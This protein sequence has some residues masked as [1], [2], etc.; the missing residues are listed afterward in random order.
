MRLDEVTVSERSTDPLRGE[1]GASFSVYQ[2]L[3]AVSAGEDLQM[4]R[5]YTIDSA[6]NLVPQQ[7]WRSR[8]PSPA[9]KFSIVYYGTEFL[10]SGLGFSPLVEAI[11]N[12]SRVG[13]L[14]IF[15]FTA[16]LFVSVDRW[17]RRSGRVG[18]LI[19]C[20]LLPSIVNWNRIDFAAT[21]K[22]FLV[23]S[24][25]LW[26]LDK[27]FYISSAFAIR[28]APLIRPVTSRPEATP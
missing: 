2:K 18:I 5:T 4:G 13:I 23:Y 19:A 9:V 21:T 6:I 7:I 20:I 28:R 26:G 16:I 17:A 11:M 12:F 25:F 10:E 27:I 3:P 22:M 8:P 15:A 14:P 1:L 24:A